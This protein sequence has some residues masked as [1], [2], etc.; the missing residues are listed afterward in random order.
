MNN[1]NNEKYKRY[2][3]FL[4]FVLRHKPEEI[5]I[6]L[7]ENGWVEISELI[8]KA[9]SKGRIYTIELI[10]S[11]V[12]SNDKKRFAIS[13]DGERIRANQGHSVKV[14]LDLQEM[15]PPKALLHGTAHKNLESIM[16]NGLDK[17]ERH[18]VHLTESKTIAAAVGQRYGKV[19][20]LKIDSETMSNQGFK[21]YR[22]EN[23]VWLVDTVPT[24]YISTLDS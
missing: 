12:E 6:Q 17:R 4:S 20:L 3:K 1:K 7:D 23:N 16:K 14:D 11:I 21:F 8:E 10:R 5:G 24:E 2:S 19:V 15:N 22:S 18:H 13:E 9:K